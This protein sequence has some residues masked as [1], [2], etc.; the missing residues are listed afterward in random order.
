MKSNRSFAQNRTSTIGL[1]VALLI[2]SIAIGISAS[3]VSAA[4]GT[5]S[6]RVFL[7]GGADGIM[8]GSDVGIGG[9]VVRAFDATGTQVGSATTALTNSTAGTYSINISSASTNAIR[10]EFPTPPG[11]ESTIVSGAGASSSVQFVNLGA[12]N[13][14]YAFFAPSDY[15]QAT[16]SL[17]SVC[18]NQ[19]S[20]D[21]SPTDRTVGITAFEPAS[22][23]TPPV[24]TDQTATAV[25]AISEKGDVGATWGLGWQK[26]KKLLWN[27]A[28]IRRHAGLGP[29]GIGGVYV[30]NLSGT[31]VASFD[32]T[33]DLGSA[34][35][36]LKGVS[37]D[38]SDAARDIVTD[39]T[40][41]P[42]RQFA[43]L[44][45]DVPGYSG[46]GTA[47]IGDLDISQ[48]SQYL[49]VTNL[50][51]RKIHR[52]ALS[53]TASAPTLGAVQ[54]W[55]V[56]N[57]HDCGATGPLRPWGL[58]TNPDG[59][60]VV[61]AVCTNES[62]DPTTKPLPG[63]GIILKLDPTKPND[64]SAWSELTTVSFSYAHN[65][66][67][68]STNA[69]YTC[70]WKAWTN[71]WN[72]LQTV[73]K[74][75]SQYWWTQP[76]ILDVEQLADGSLVLGISDRLSYQLGSAN[77]PPLSNATTASA[78]G[79]TAGDTL[80]LCKTAS[81][82]QQESGGQC[83][84]TH[85][86]KNN[87]GDTT[88]FFYDSFGHPETTIG[89]LALGRGQI[90]VSAMDPAAY[91]L[92][93]VRWVSA[94][95]GTQT[96][97]LNMTSVATSSG[98]LGFGK[99]AGMGDLEALCDNAPLQIGNRV[100]YDYN[101]DGIQD[102]GEDPVVG[103]TV[104]LYDASQ[105]LVGTAITNANGE[106][107]F[108]STN[109]E[110]ATGGA[111]P[112]E[113][114]G[115]LEENTAYTVVLDNPDDCATGKPLD[116]WSLTLSDQSINGSSPE[117]DNSLDSDATPQGTSWC[118]S[119][120][121]TVPIAPMSVG[122]VNH[123]YDIGFWKAGFA[124]SSTTTIPGATT[125]TTVPNPTATS[126]IKVSVGDYVWW[127]LD[128]DGLQDNNDIPIAGVVLTITKADGSAVL[129]VD[130][131]AVSTTITDADGK[132]SFDNLPPGQY[133]VTVTP[134]PGAITTAPEVGGNR[135]KNS[136]NGSATS[137]NL[138][139]DG[140]RDPTLDFGFYLPSVSVGNFV[141]RDVK[142]DGYQNRKD[143]GL[144]G[145]KLTLRT[146]DGRLV[147]DVYGRPVTPVVTKA[148]GKYLFN[149]LPEGQYKVLITYR[150]G[151][152]ATTADRPNRKLNSSTSFAISR[153]LLDGQSDL[154]LDF[155]VVGAIG[156][157]L[158]ITR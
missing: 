49:W 146:A 78:T 64:A 66:D 84:G 79:W 37:D 17:A 69:G 2:S 118:G 1:C 38:Y 30:H 34:N 136:S 102:A 22:T 114:G 25:T 140:Q 28:V 60:L 135:E 63:D 157:I 112:D 19:G 122:G 68:C 83:A 103:V 20:K 120:A 139:T 131:K 39:I 154:T 32:L 113:F 117:R 97:A 47:G 129:D 90:A 14:N 59:T 130:G 44:S 156:R 128:R 54:T 121:A 116:G 7:D 141:W 126:T 86:F 151:F 142:G 88:E 27:S 57:G 108:T 145:F 43:V 58:D 52:I 87:R 104:R 153:P 124:P 99:S 45:R 56:S 15:C 95:S 50:F 94:L 23:G 71:D 74:K 16:M 123:T 93:G 98:A 138:T 77:Y 26:S 53:G 91:F 111:T 110:T 133:I 134:P 148:D 76:M 5:V 149:N 31:Q 96:N 67:Y 72:A 152:R 155:G 115:G 65:Y 100:W 144:A 119:Q 3:D 80:L 92:S 21:L 41:A 137:V 10:V 9:L 61:A 150:R 13:V 36:T 107:Y 73:A 147:T 106:Y 51:E 8:N 11:Y 125:T 55:T 46:V 85:S 42:T 29:K 82:W 62:A 6:G 40:A 70:T 48:D 158:P 24:A 35:L 105:T 101:H 18:I 4:S 81:G 143:K 12:T 127:D 75:G 132:Y 109:T 33:S 89:G